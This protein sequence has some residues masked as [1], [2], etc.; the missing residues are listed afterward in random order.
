MST[1]TDTQV[2]RVCIVNRLSS[3]NQMDLN[4]E[5]LPVL[6]AIQ[7]QLNEEF[8]HYWGIS[9]KLYYCPPNV[10]I[11]KNMWSS[12]LLDTS[13]VAGALG[14][15]DAN[16]NGIPQCKTFVKT[17][18]NSRAQW[19]VTLDHEI[20]E[21]LTDVWGM[22]SFFQDFT[23]GMKRLVAKEVCLTGDTKIPLLDG[24]QVPIK[25]LVGRD[26]FWVY[27]CDKDGKIV[28]G[29]GHSAR[30]TRKQSLIVEVTLDNDEKIRC[31]PDHLFLLRDG[32]Y[33]EASKLKIGQSLMPLY[34]RKEVLFN[35]SKKGFT[36]DY[37]YEQVFDNS[38]DEWI[39]THRMVQ[40]YCP[41]GYVRHHK[42]LN[43][44]NNS[45]ENI[46]L[47]KWQDHSRLHRELLSE[48]A[49][50]WSKEMVEKGL[51]PF[52]RPDV[53]EKV[54]KSGSAR[55][56]EYNKTEKHRKEASKVAKIQIFKNVH[57]N[58]IVKKIVN[59]LAGKRLKEY[60]KTQKHKEEILAYIHS[61][62]GI[63]IASNTA[64]KNNHQRWHVDRNIINKEKCELCALYNH[65]VKS[66]KVLD[67]FEDVYDITVDKY[68]N[69]ALSS[70]VFVHNCDPCE[71]DKYGYQK[72]GILL[73]NFVTP[74]WL[75]PFEDIAEFD[76]DIR[77]DYRGIIKK[78]FTTLPGCHQS[79]YYIAGAPSGIPIQKWSSKTFNL[80]E[81]Q[82]IY[83]QPQQNGW[84]ISFKTPSEELVKE[85]DVTKEEV[86]EAIDAAFHPAPGSRRDIRFKGYRHLQ[87]N[88][89]TNLEK[90][91]EE[92]MVGKNILEIE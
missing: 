66:V 43:R 67:R 64:K 41:K 88:T 38:N 65:K 31:T 63:E 77:Y 39:Y 2:K 72:D 4:K 89:A 44:F 58:P 36:K 32:T 37:D 48:Y 47:M 46:E 71:A 23:S 74:Y 55:L 9:A 56:R 17:V 29:K 57:N 79:Y 86:V 69:F 92:P 26:H 18:K 45:P 68:H 21:M 33:E 82:E 51:H 1:I 40:T 8:K 28:P 22:E 50:K 52:Q 62:R 85:F 3:A 20:L 91:L 83:S 7:K 30:L 75:H 24:T 12:L 25:D 35:G 59:E 54:E 80:G 5:I 84:V 10:A 61:E 81:V 60:N 49:K 78:S 15:H 14:Y 42:D 53:R 16:D 70:G 87:T 27:S 13:D 73:S 90:K 34:R 11:P 76:N 6:R 19:S